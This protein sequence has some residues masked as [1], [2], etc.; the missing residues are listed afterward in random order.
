[1]PCFQIC[2][3]NA[4]PSECVLSGDQ[5]TGLATFDS[6]TEMNPCHDFSRGDNYTTYRIIKE[7]L[8]LSLNREK[9]YL[10]FH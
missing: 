4:H 2:G 10:P 5:E 3:P 8:G 7:L 6:L 9:C 1:M